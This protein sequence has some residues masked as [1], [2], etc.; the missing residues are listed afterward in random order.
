MIDLHLHLDGSMRPTTV[1]ELLEAK[2]MNPFAADEEAIAYFSRDTYD[3]LV[4]YL[5]RFKY[6]VLA[7]QSFEAVKRAVLELADDAENSGVHYAEIRFAPLLLVTKDFSQ[8][9]A[10]LAA[11]EGVKAA[12]EEIGGIRIGIILCCMRG[13]DK[14]ANAETIR[15]AHKY[16]GDVVCALDI[17]GDEEHY[18]MEIY[19][20]EFKLARKLDI[21]FTI[22]AG[23][24]LGA[25]NIWKA[26]E[27]GAKRIGHGVRCIEDSTLVDYLARHEI[28]LEIC[29]T[30]NIQTRVFGNTD[31]YPLKELLINEVHVTLN[32]DNMTISNT[33]LDKERD[34]CKR[35]FGLT[36]KDIELMN[37]FSKEAAFLAAN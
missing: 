14:E 7:L 35:R 36:D 32:T 33:N 13:A 28:P 3:N 34:L 30:S 26:L 18:P 5:S 22:H 11:I 15:L 24:A 29:P 37:N 21:P 6:P 16:L 31:Y 20:E 9:E 27:M 10:V 12:R 19:E 2:G 23:E 8:E 4:D 17:A 1:R 25:E